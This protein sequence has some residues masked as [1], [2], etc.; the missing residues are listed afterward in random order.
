M[1]RVVVLIFLLVV[2]YYLV[3][4]LLK[5][6]ENSSRAGESVDKRVAELVRDPQCGT[7]I[8]PSQAVSAR[9]G[10]HTYHFCSEECKDRFLDKSRKTEEGGS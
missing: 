10:R 4:N 9:V 6:S 7:Y 3:K 8:L 5:G 2:L 1:I